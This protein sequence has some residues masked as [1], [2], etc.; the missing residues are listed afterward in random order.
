MA[1]AAGHA[2]NASAPGSALNDE[3]A[4]TH[5]ALRSS[6]SVA[7]TSAVGHSIPSFFQY[8]KCSFGAA[9]GACS[10]RLGACQ[11]SH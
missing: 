3:L 10:K 2:A 5:K 4:A 7:R 1:P 8:R 11:R 6:I 9:R